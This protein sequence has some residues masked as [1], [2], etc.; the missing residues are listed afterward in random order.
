MKKKLL[1]AGS[2]LSSVLLSSTIF[3]G[4]GKW[5]DLFDQKLSER[6]KETKA[7][8]LKIGQEFE[9]SPKVDTI[10]M[11]LS[12][13]P[14]DK[15]TS[16]DY[17]LAL[18]PYYV[19]NGILNMNKK[20]RLLQIVDYKNL[21]VRQPDF[22][23]NAIDH[24]GDD[25]KGNRKN[26]DG[27]NEQIRINLSQ[28]KAGF[29]KFRKV[30]NMVATISS[31]DG[32]SFT[33]AKEAFFRITET[34]VGTWDTEE[35]E[36]ARFYLDGLDETKGVIIGHLYYNKSR[37]R[38]IFKAEGKDVEAVKDYGTVAPSDMEETIKR[39]VRTHAASS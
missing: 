22:P 8:I 33:L 18:F 20:K 17:D 32:D 39:M 25:I 16:L 38:W 14:E 11:G 21:Q 36:L 5:E 4:G 10:V 19:P 34:K 24:R 31:S 23:N 13:E 1:V 28:I 26:S 37:D 3:A 6:K 29:A 2:I 27:D 35:R 30:R 9:I 12:W 15:S 7:E